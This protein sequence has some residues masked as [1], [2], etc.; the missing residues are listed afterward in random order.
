MY[1]A[2]SN[3]KGRYV[4]FDKVMH[5][6]AVATL[7]LE[8][9]LRRA[10]E[11]GE[12][13]LHYQP[14]VRTGAGRA[15]GFEALVR[16]EHPERGLVPPGEFIPA[17]EET[18]LIIPMGEWVLRE[19]CRQ[20]REWQREFPSGEPLFVSVNLSAKQFTQRD[21][22]EVV[23]RALT[24]SGLEARCLK[25]EITETAVMEN[26]EAAAAMLRRLRGIGVQ[27]G[28]D[29]FGTGYSSLSHLHRFPVNTLKVDRSFVGRMEEASEY[30]E[31]VRTIISL[32]HT[33]RMEVVAE[34]VETSGQRARLEALGC[35]YSQGYFFSKPLPAAAAAGYLAVNWQAADAAAGTPTELHSMVK[36]AGSYPM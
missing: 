17:A 31:I 4:V 10:V 34:G 15:A 35:E 18:D 24:A 36:A 19:A 2:K 1:R 27:L 33:L 9:E 22:V 21:L 7:K 32:A 25:L 16:W 5:A 8:S 12:F 28:I 14:I 13:R 11:D 3:G 26:A 30:G 29:D 23:E 6:R 20:A